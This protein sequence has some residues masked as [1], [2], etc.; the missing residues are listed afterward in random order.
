VE[1]FGRGLDW[2]LSRL[3]A[4]GPAV[5]SNR[6]RARR[7]E[8]ADP[9]GL[10]RRR[11]KET[12][13]PR[14]R[15][16]TIVER[17]SPVLRPGTV[18]SAF[19]P[20]GEPDLRLRFMYGSNSL[21]S[22]GARVNTIANAATTTAPIRCAADISVAVTCPRRTT[23]RDLESS[24][25]HSFGTRRIRGRTGRATPAP[26]YTTRTGGR[27]VRARPDRRGVGKTRTA[28]PRLR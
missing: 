19:G 5:T 16:A 15:N 22:H 21:I 24:D 18:R 7:S 3:E 14:S 25:G 10:A 23:G 8:V 4:L 6:G 11:P 12:P 2:E 13:A 20:A 27:L 9:V 28:T 17:A 26:R 1:N